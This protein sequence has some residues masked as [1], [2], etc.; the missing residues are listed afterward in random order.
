MIPTARWGHGV[1]LAAIRTAHRVLGPVGDPELERGFLMCSTLCF[2]RAA[3][4]FEIEALPPGPGGLAGPPFDQVIYEFLTSRQSAII[5]TYLASRRARFG[6]KLTPPLFVRWDGAPMTRGGVHWMMKRL[7]E[8]AGIR[9]Q[10]PKGALVHA[11]RH[12]FATSVARSGASGTELQRLLGHE[13][14]A[15]T[16]RYVDATA[17]EV[18]GAAR[19]GVVY[20]ALG[21]LGETA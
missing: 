7:Y 10:V 20:Q 1:R 13:S 15:T 4:N 9:A 18:R 14:L 2:H 16:Q 17:R 3:S 11:L 21:Q 8:E 6:D 12:T 5:D 19:G